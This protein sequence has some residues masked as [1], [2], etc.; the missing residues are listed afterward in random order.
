MRVRTTR[1][2]VLRGATFAVAVAATALAV[3]GPAGAQ[4]T[5]TVALGQQL[6]LLWIVIGAI[7]VIFM[8]A[9]FA[10][11]ETG[12]CRAKHA[13]HVVS[14]NFAIFGLGF[15]AF[16]LVGFP[17]A[18]GG[19]SYDLPGFDW[20]YGATPLGG[21]LVGSGSW[22]FLW[23]GGWALSGDK[24]TP[25][26]AA[27]FLYMVAFMDTVATIPTGSMAERWRWKSFVL[28]GLFCGAIYYP[29][30]TAWTWGGGWLGKTWDTLGLGAGYVDFAGSGVV[31]AVGGVAALAGAVVLGPRL[32]K[33]AEDG[34]PRAIPGH[35]IPMAMLG[36]FILLF[37]WFGFNAASTF[38][39]TD[40][41]FATVATNTAI[42]GAFG[43]VVAMLWMTYVRGDKP[44]PGMMA[45]GMLAGLVAI[46]AP[47][48]FTSP[49]WSAVI[50]VIAGVL[51]IESVLFVE[52]R[53][54][55]DDPVGAISVHGVCGT[56]GVLAVGIFANGSYGGGWNGS[57]VEAVE[58]V[59]KGEFGQLG[60]Q[61]LGAVV[62]WT[63]ILG[64]AYAFFKLQ[65]T[66]TKG[67][68][69]SAAE[70]ELMGLDLP[71]MGVLAY[72]E[73]SG[74]GGLGGS[75]QDHSHAASPEGE[76]VGAE[77]VA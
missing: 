60:A 50:G 64:L 24:I 16:F 44:D 63:V 75:V 20:G 66:L 53:L 41:Q 59:V 65:D 12:F 67:G 25:A 26:V 55:L 21:A 51:V 6:N 17:L 11:V 22:V 10:L 5:E 56:F 68:I 45:N 35:H 37:G 7:L 9:G 34:T 13:S 3:A 74:V 58:G 46:T 23:H 15:V 38:A 49:A 18:F 1:K 14:T 61:A 42:A 29:L 72:P 73:F 70:D 19:Y 30:F 31:H 2:R 77:P 52:R 39:A 54:H 76:R 28:W 36:T 8:Q 48:A 27:F 71:E 32:G 33:F 4:S 69:R 47:C 40:V 62:I 57:D 43:A